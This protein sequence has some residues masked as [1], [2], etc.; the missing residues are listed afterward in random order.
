ML[1]VF[2]GKWIGCILLLALENTCSF[3]YILIFEHDWSH[4]VY[5]NQMV[6]ACISISSSLYFVNMMQVVIIAIAFDYC[7]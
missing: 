2:L 6:C 5:F 1:T 7:L 4:I 3:K